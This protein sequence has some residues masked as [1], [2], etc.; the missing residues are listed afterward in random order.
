MRD[1]FLQAMSRAANTVCVVTTNGLAGKHG[2]TVSAMTSVSVENPAPT[3]LICVHHMSSACEAIQRN[4]VF[5][6]NI[7]GS[8]QAQVSDC[9]AGR[10]QAKGI[11]KFDCATWKAGGTGGPILVDA[12]ASFDCNLMHDFLVGSHRIFVGQVAAVE[13]AATG[14]PLIYYD[15]TYSTPT[16]F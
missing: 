10:T 11:E 14:A 16:P 1:A 4:R 9:F 2:V 12:Q 8:E 7:L 5:C 3:L 15:R 13:S 6:A